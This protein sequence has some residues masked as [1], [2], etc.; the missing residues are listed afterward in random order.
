[1]FS[2]F[3]NCKF[4][5]FAFINTIKAGGSESMYRLGGGVPRPP[6][7]RKMPYKIGIG[8]KCMFIA[9]FFKASS[10]KKIR[11]ITFLVWVLGRVEKNVEKCKKYFF[12]LKQLLKCD[13]CFYIHFSRAFQKYSF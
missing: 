12:C 3:Q 11:W 4:V 8:L 6:S 7:F 13:T 5:K 1:M 10:L 9:K 2:P